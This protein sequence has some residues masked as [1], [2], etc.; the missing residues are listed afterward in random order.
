A[1]RARPTRRSRPSSTRT[2]CPSA[3]ETTPLSPTRWGRGSPRGHPLRYPRSVMETTATAPPPASTSGSLD[4]KTLDVFR[5]LGYLYADLDPLHRLPPEPEELLGQ[6]DPATAAQARRWYC[7]PLGVEFMHVEDPERR[8]WL[9][10]RIEADEPMRADR[11]RILELLIRGETF[12]Q[13]LQA[14]YLGT[15]RFSIEGVESLL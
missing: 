5:R 14:R 10:E 2:P 3:R 15:K 11:S 13:M 4:E 1:T 9:Q 7:G 6:A 12:E 8:R